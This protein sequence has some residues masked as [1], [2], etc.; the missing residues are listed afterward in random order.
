MTAR[1]GSSKPEY[2]VLGI[3]IVTYR[4][5]LNAAINY[6]VRDERRRDEDT[7]VYRFDSSIEIEGTTTY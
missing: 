4:I 3:G 1:K 7:A 6:E 5:R 2:T